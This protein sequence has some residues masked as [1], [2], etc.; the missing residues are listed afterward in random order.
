MKIKRFDKM[1]VK[2]T[3]IFLYKTKVDISVFF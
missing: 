3:C 1:Q 2:F